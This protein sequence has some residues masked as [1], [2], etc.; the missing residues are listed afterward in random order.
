M[1]K[2]YD[3]YTCIFCNNNMCILHGVCNKCYE[4]ILKIEDE[5]TVLLDISELRYISDSY[6]DMDTN[7]VYYQYYSMIHKYFKIKSCGKFI[8]YEN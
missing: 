3:I 7:R 1:D 8:K 2:P 4:E 5:K 6:L